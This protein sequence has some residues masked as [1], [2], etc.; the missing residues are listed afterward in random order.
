MAFRGPERRLRTRFRVSLPFTLKSDSQEARGTTR[1]VS[2]LGI[3]AV[4]DS[5]FPQAQPVDCLLHLAASS[6]PIIAHGTIIHCDPLPEPTPEGSHELGVFFKEFEQNGESNLA[7]FLEQMAHKEEA[8]LKA[9]YR[10]LKQKLAARKRRKRMEE[11]KKR[12]R[13]Q[14]RLRRRR[15][16]L[17]KLRRQQRGSKRSSKS[18]RKKA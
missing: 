11:L 14:E 5:T 4:I 12:R 15:L 2:L 7:R 18:R 13:R 9:G 6:K 8:A 17:A 1:N 10:A 3:S 16:R